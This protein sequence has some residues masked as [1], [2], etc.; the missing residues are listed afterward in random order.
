M[1]PACNFSVKGLSQSVV[2]SALPGLVRHIIHA[3]DMVSELKGGEGE[4]A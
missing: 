2:L 4:G 1:V 3:E